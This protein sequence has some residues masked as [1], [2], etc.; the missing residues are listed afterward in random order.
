MINMHYYYI[1]TPKTPKIVKI[2][3]MNFHG[4]LNCVY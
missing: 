4:S 1:F 2:N 3:Q